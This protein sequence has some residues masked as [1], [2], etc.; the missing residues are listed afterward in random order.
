MV[1]SSLLCCYTTAKVKTRRGLGARKHVYMPHAACASACPMMSRVCNAV[2]F[3]CYW[4][5]Y[6]CFSLIYLN[7]N[8]AVG[9]LI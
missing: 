7:I 4:I 1:C 3:V 6:L 2:A 9:F 8:Q 5:I